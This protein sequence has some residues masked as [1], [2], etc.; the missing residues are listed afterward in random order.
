ME[1]E[2][3]YTEEQ[4]KRNTKLMKRSKFLVISF[5]IL[6]LIDLGLFIFLQ[7]NQLFILNVNR[8]EGMN[9][10]PD[11]ARVFSFIFYVIILI[12]FFVFLLFAYE[13]REHRR[14]K[15]EEQIDRLH[16]FEK[17]FDVADLFSVVPVFLLVI[18]ILSG[19][20]FSFAKVDGIS[21]E[22]TYCDQDTVIISYTS[23]YQTDE[24]VIVKALNEFIIKRLVAVPG[25]TLV[26]DDNGVSVN[27]NIVETYFDP[28]TPH[29]YI[30]TTL[31]E[32][33]YFVLGDNRGNSYDS[34]Y[35][36][37]IPQADML[38]RVI[39]RISNSTCPV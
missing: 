10:T 25:D 4:L 12:S 3:Q 28:R 1:E 5:F 36:G 20:F 35:I 30:N 9:A 22:P 17:W 15:L 39:Y 23:N 19:F 27:G 31:T 26:V 11:A 13:Y 33:E 8:T 16:G 2:L 7:R 6:F 29:V 14:M 21:M 38:G 24:I 34:R 18:S 37:L 32:G